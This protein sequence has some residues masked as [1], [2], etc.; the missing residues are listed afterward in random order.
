MAAFAAMT[1]VA[2]AELTYFPVFPDAR[3]AHQKPIS[4][5]VALVLDR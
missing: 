3:E 5:A 2:N 1:M 4:F